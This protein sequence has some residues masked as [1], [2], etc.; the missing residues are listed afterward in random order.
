MLNEKATYISYTIFIKWVIK[1]QKNI[2]KEIL[3]YSWGGG[4]QVQEFWGTNI[5]LAFAFKHCIALKHFLKRNKYGV[6]FKLNVYSEDFNNYK[7][8]LGSEFFNQIR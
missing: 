8:T 3:N 5:K 1:V 7:S 6:L 4:L 2:R